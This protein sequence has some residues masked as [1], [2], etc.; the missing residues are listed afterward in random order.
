M[1][2][3][4][5]VEPLVPPLTGRGTRRSALSGTRLAMTAL[6]AS[7]VA[8]SGATFK[9]EKVHAPAKAEKTVV[10]NAHKRPDAIPY[11][12]QFAHLFLASAI[13]KIA[14]PGEA[15]C[16]EQK[17]LGDHRLRHK[18]NLIRETGPSLGLALRLDRLRGG[19]AETWLRFGS[20]VHLSGVAS[21]LA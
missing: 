20:A 10:A 15:A 2:L 7:I 3:S 19:S 18:K 16:F 5:L 12:V 13:E 11:R 1:V 9:G 4:C 6:A 14:E 21:H 8:L 17:A